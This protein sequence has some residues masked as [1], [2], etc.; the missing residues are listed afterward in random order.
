MRHGKLVLSRQVGETVVVAGNVRVTVIE[1]KGERVRLAFE[2]PKSVPVDRL[3]VHEAK[4][5][6][7]GHVD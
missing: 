6:E 2:A 1:I 3:E 7:A 5:R 4:Q